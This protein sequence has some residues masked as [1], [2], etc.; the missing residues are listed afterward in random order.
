MTVGTVYRG[1]KVPFKFE[2]SQPKSNLE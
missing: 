1:Y 2:L